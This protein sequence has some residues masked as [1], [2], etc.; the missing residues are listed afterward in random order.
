MKGIL[1]EFQKDHEGKIE[2]RLI[3]V[4]KNPDAGEKY[5]IRVVPT[6][7]FL[8]PSGKELY[9]QEGLMTSEDLLKKWEELGYNISS[10][11]NGI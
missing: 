7:I 9:R 2:T 4:W 5:K 3:D 10:P 1:A 11:E 8:D 6:L